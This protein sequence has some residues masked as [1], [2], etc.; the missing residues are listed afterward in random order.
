V[1]RDR[2]LITG[3]SGLLAL[4]WAAF[5]SNR[6]DVTLALHNRSIDVSFAASVFV[7]LADTEV[8]SGLIVE[9]Q[10]DVLVNC[11]AMANVEA[12]EADPDAARAANTCLPLVLSSACKQAGV[13]FVQ[14]STDHLSSGDAPF[15]RETD[16]IEPQNEYAKTKAEGEQAVLESNSDAIVVRT[17]FFG[18][19]TAYRQSFSD[20]IL[21]SL[22]AGK[23]IDLFEDVFFS[24]TYMR[25]VFEIVRTLLD[26][27]ESGLINCCGRDRVSKYEFGLNLASA[28]GYDNA[29]IN[30]VRLSDR[31]DLVSRPFD[32][33]LSIEKV[34]ELLGSP[35]PS[36]QDGIFAMMSDAELPAIK[37]LRR[38]T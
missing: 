27:K 35:V 28:M 6:Y 13:S 34:T 12:C 21:S 7:D 5:A 15:N 17:N 30:S 26:N 20:W 1:R 36:A 31:S 38:L 33:S 18:W 22:V 23:D 4:N 11:A 37:E 32:M 3:G 16:P 9:H 14:I 10:A 24:P 2:L 19:G 25:H 29:K 8:V